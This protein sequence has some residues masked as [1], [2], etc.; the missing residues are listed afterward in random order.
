[1]AA[2]KNDLTA[3][4]G[5]DSRTLLMPGRFVIRIFLPARPPP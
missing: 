5:D 3:F 1:M 2:R 4:N